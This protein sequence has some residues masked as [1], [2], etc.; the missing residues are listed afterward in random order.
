MCIRD[1]LKN[2]KKILP[3]ALE[4]HEQKGRHPLLLSGESQGK[5]GFMKDMRSGRVYLQD[6]KSGDIMDELEVCRAAGSGLS[7]VCV[8]HF[9]K[10][11]VADLFVDSVGDKVKALEKKQRAEIKQLRLQAKSA[12]PTR[13]DRDDDGSVPA[14]ILSALPAVEGGATGSAGKPAVLGPKQEVAG[15]TDPATRDTPRQDYKL[16]DPKKEPDVVPTPSDR[17]G[18]QCAYKISDTTESMRRLMLVNEATEEILGQAS[19]QAAEITDETNPLVICASFGAE[20]YKR[21]TKRGNFPEKREG[22]NEWSAVQTEY[23]WKADFMDFHS[24]QIR[25]PIIARY[26]EEYPEFREAEFLLVNCLN[27]SD[28]HHDK[29]L[30]D[31]TGRHPRTMLGIAKYLDGPEQDR[32]ADQFMQ[33][34]TWNPDRRPL[35][36]LH[37]CKRERHRSIGVR[38][39]NRTYL[40]ERFGELINVIDGPQPRFAR[41]ICGGNV[42]TCGACA[43]TDT[44]Y[45]PDLDQAYDIYR[46]KSNKYFRK[47]GYYIDQQKAREEQ[48]RAAKRWQKK[49]QRDDPDQGTDRDQDRDRRRKVDRDTDEPRN[50]YLDEQ[51]DLT[52][53]FFRNLPFP[54]VTATRDKLQT[55][56]KPQT[57]TPPSDVTPVADIIRIVKAHSLSAENVREMYQALMIDAAPKKD[58]SP[59]PRSVSP[60]PDTDDQFRKDKPADDEPA[61]KNIRGE[62]LMSERHRTYD[63]Y[64]ENR[65]RDPDVDW[66]LKH[67][68]CTGQS[69]IDIDPTEIA[70]EV[71]ENI[72]YKREEEA[73]TKGNTK[74]KR[75]FI[76][77]YGPDELRQNMKIRVNAK[78]EPWDTKINYPPSM[79]DF[80]KTTLARDWRSLEWEVIEDRV[81]ADFVTYS[82]D[83]A[84]MPHGYEKMLVFLQEPRYNFRDEV[85]FCQEMFDEHSLAGFQGLQ[86]IDQAEVRTVT[87]KQRSLINDGVEKINAEDVAMRTCLKATHRPVGTGGCFTALARVLV[88]SLIHI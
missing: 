15:G 9:P 18:A 58:K 32:F 7:V 46:E 40:R 85:Y 26:C 2:S 75:N 87:K 31:H 68:A 5:L 41:H 77:Y 84:S 30:R 60:T 43:H 10:K 48:E 47:Y 78:Y 54:E 62:T 6:Y 74:T 51:V 25:F 70:S 19:Q 8:S 55:I 49:K 69:Y 86:D 14:M 4:S 39:H 24:D 63:E 64:G 71:L 79:K 45:L 42:A 22:Y 67:S 36:I 33:W 73:R 35:V 29:D 38:H 59:S 80:R 44:N 61:G 76:T 12:S 34:L 1:S 65:D 57:N 66:N 3:A 37:I 17:R 28:P 21:W 16:Q 83:M 81:P 27:Y 23:G 88:L 20:N 11:I 52:R 50:T 82:D 56:F 53:D 72:F 13:T